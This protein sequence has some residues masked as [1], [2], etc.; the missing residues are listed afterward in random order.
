MCL[1]V[2]SV[3]NAFLLVA[4]LY[5]HTCPVPT[6]LFAK[7]GSLSTCHYAVSACLSTF[8][9]AL[10]IPGYP[11]VF[12]AFMSAYLSDCSACLPASLLHPC[13]FSCSS[14]PFL[15]VCLLVSLLCLLASLFLGLLIFSENGFHLSLCSRLSTCLS[16]WIPLYGFVYSWLKYFLTFF[17]F[18]L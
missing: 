7:P 2:C 8:Q 18:K 14:M 17:T 3:C 6:C 16:G 9:S 12:F 1:S 11:S 13:A 10:P 15:L 4:P 5:L